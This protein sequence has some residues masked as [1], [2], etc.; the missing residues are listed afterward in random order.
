MKLGGEELTTR[1]PESQMRKLAN[2]SA[3]RQF[4]GGPTIT[5]GHETSH[6]PTRFFFFYFFFRGGFDERDR[7]GLALMDL[8]SW[9][10]RKCSA[11]DR[12]KPAHLQA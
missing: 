2:T 12:G 10:G 11:H 9:E 3:T 1:A 7:Q 6:A 5:D 4:I 8:P